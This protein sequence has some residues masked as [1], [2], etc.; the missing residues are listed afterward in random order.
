M[1]KIILFALLGLF[2]LNCSAMAP[3]DKAVL[4]ESLRTG[5]YKHIELSDGPRRSFE[6]EIDGKKMN[7]EY[8]N[9]NS[10]DIVCK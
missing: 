1:K 4:E 5:A 3:E 7:C 8:R 6:L 9:T 2:S 10:D